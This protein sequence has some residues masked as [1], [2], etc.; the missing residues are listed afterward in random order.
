MQC[1]CFNRVFNTVLQSTDLVGRGFY[2]T[3]LITPTVHYKNG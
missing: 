2:F 3:K 1:E